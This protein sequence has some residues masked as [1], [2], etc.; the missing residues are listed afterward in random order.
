M[1][2]STLETAE[3]SADTAA[4]FT[5]PAEVILKGTPIAGRLQICCSSEPPIKTTTDIAGIA[6][7]AGVVSSGTC[8][9][10]VP[11][12]EL[13]GLGELTIQIT[14]AP[15]V[16]SIVFFNGTNVIGAF[17]GNGVPTGTLVFG[18]KCKFEN[19]SC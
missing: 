18:A 13:P 15:T 8:S 12:S 17:A 10:K 2:N 9:F 19:G 1:Q 11:A 14:I 3:Q 16:V 5:W 6:S 4:N 7:A